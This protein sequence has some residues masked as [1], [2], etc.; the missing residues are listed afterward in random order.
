[1]ILTGMGVEMEVTFE[2]EDGSPVEDVVERY[3]LKADSIQP[4]RVYSDCPHASWVE[5]GTRPASKKSDSSKPVLDI[6]MEWAEKKLGLK[7]AEARDV[8]GAIYYKILVEGMPP[9]PYFRPAIHDTLSEV[10]SQSET[11]LSDGYSLEDIA[12]SI[13]ERAVLNLH[14][15]GQN[16]THAL[17]QSIKVDTGRMGP[18]GYDG[19]M[20]E[21]DIPEEVWGSSELGRDG[22]SRPDF[23]RWSRW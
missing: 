6:L 22:V 2:T 23:R 1:M 17:E 13:A 9:A 21:G 14:R 19:R 16:Y 4:A 20:I 11:W 5:F 7:G 12:N 8:A 3:L 10:E 15:N 18:I